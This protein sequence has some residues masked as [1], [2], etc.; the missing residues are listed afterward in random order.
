LL[1]STAHGW[2]CND[3]AAT[4][5]L[6]RESLTE[7]DPLAVCNDGTGAAFYMQEN[8][9]SND[10]LV[11]LAGGGWC[12]DLESC[13]GRFN[14]SL[15]PHQACSSS[16]QSKP[17]FM[18]SKDYPPA[19]GK[20]GIFDVHEQSPLHAWNL[21]YVPYCTSDAFMGDGTFGSWQF[22]GARVVRAVLKKLKGRLESGKRILFGGGSAGGRGAMVF[23]DE[24]SHAFPQLHVQG[25]LDSPFYLDVASFSS[26]F[27]GFQQQHLNVLKNFNATSVVSDRCGQRFPDQQWKCLFGQ[28]RMPLLRTQYLMAAAQY[29]SWQLSHLVHG[30]DGLE[31]RPTYT[32]A[33]KQY[34]EDFAQKTR[35]E[36]NRLK[37]VQPAGSSLYSSACYEHHISESSSFWA[38]KVNG[39]SQA[40]V[41]S[42]LG[43]APAATIAG[44]TNYNCGC[45]NGTDLA[46]LLEKV[47]LL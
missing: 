34:A 36:L 19:C 39:L 25:F 43:S 9:S 35:K 33:E 13:E 30:Y 1:I 42:N 5:F 24:V 6:Q 38:K 40:D 16:T 8:A 41:L 32:A 23:L 7:V 46:A 21:V 15:F 4:R 47:F 18:S 22:R 14:G 20:T 31:N 17:C 3:A 45:S 28:H 29:D 12:Y 2:S 10:W 26:K 27:D 37:R 44:C 11:Y